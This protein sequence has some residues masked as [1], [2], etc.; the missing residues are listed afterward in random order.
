MISPIFAASEW[1]TE[2]KLPDAEKRNVHYSTG[3]FDQKLGPTCVRGIRYSRLKTRWER[4]I[5]TA[6]RSSPAI[7]GVALCT[8]GVGET[9]YSRYKS[10]T[11]EKGIQMKA[12]NTILIKPNQIG[13][14][15]ETVTT[16]GIARAH[17]F[18][19]DHFPH[20][21][22]ETEDGL[23]SRDLAVGS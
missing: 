22:G 2:E 3:E 8:A 14:I 9:I 16:V 21:S 11:V 10:G 6:G 12:G 17:G 19:N 20:G 7:S 4:T 18:K 23:S 15:S 5:G 13:T 1:I